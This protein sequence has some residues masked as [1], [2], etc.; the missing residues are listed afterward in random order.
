MPDKPEQTTPSQWELGSILKWLVEDGRFLPDVDELTR[1]LG[2]QMLNSGAP[3]WRLRLSMR[4]LHPLITATTSVWER[5]RQ[6]T[7]HLQSPHG[8]EGRSGYIGSPMEIIN[9][10]RA[11]FRKRLQDPLSETDHNVLHELKARGGTDYFGVPMIF[12]DGAM[13]ILVLTT[14]AAD[15]FS[16]LDL[17]QFEELSSILAPI[18][19][20]FNARLVS[21][22]IAEAYLGPRTGRRVLDGRI[23]RGDIENIQAAI[24]VSDIRDWTGLNIR[25]RAEDALALANRYFEVVAEAVEGN[26]GEILKFIGDGVLAVFP[27]DSEAP[28]ATAACER[29]LAAARQALQSAEQSGLSDEVSFGMGMHFGDVLY[30]NVGSKTRLDFTVLGQAVNVAARI[31]GL[32]GKFNQPVLFSE[33]F[34]DRLA[35][36]TKLV[37]EEIL[38]GQDEASKVFTTSDDLRQAD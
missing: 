20:V 6:F 21:R 32:C 2:D 18:M 33:E 13:A 26:G 28:D 10:T 4:T 34:A 16:D 27:T 19:E 8:L 7:T 36:T 24:L 5:D 22:A 25:V 14:D 31:E 3:L 15:G 38:K 29:A 17:E 35:E 30:G 11:P 23:T 1:Q 12:S 37:A 9:K